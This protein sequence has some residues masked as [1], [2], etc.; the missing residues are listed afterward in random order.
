[1]RWGWFT[2][3]L[4]L[5]MTLALALFSGCTSYDPCTDFGF[6]G[7]KTLIPSQTNAGTTGFT[8]RVEAANAD[9]GDTVKWN[10]V[11]LTTTTVAKGQYIEASVPD[12]FLAQAGEADV[13]ISKPAC[14]TT[15]N[16]LTFTITGSGAPLAI[17]NSNP[18]P[19]GT[20]NQGYTIIFS[21]I[22]GTPPYNWSI[23]MTGALPPELALDANFASNGK[24]SGQLVSAGTF[25]FE[26]DV[27]DSSSTTVAKTFDVT[28]K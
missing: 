4:L 24:V 16:A 10:D 18:L 2:G 3:L 14:D 25:H 21:A 8:I 7:I 13:S 6:V 28:V 11:L 27:T 23:P 15:S 9:S 20:L 19:D 17:T 12:S 26:V 22:G 1:M 5:S